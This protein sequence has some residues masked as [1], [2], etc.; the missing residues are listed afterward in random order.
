MNF[1]RSGEI[2][3][4]NAGLKSLNES[5]SILARE[6]GRR[7]GMQVKA[8]NL[9]L[10]FAVDGPLPCGEAHPDTQRSLERR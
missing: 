3:C 4:Y 2:H 6:R 9:T 10:A 8:R 7:F 1:K 5:K